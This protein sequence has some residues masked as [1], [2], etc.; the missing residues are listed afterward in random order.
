LT[1]A[2]VLLVGAGSYAFRLG[3]LL[4]GGRFR[5]G[6]RQQRTLG[7]AGM[8]GIA[9]LL[10][11]GIVGFGAT[12]GLLAIGS[13][14][15]AVGVAAFFAW[16]GRSMALVVLAGGMVYAIVELTVAFLG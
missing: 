6:E 3:P 2:A 9:A 1:W 12:G 8:G 7:H 10:V 4:L 14:S 11:T 15:A 13:V 16:W 5:L